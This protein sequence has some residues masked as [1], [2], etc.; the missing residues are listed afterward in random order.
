MTVMTSFDFALL[1]RVKNSMP[2]QIFV[3]TNNFQSSD[4]FSGE[5]Y[6]H[7]CT[8]V[9]LILFNSG[10]GKFKAHNVVF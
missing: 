2:H 5:A 1:N 6:L 3:V 10:F 8:E 4:K 9:H 7:F